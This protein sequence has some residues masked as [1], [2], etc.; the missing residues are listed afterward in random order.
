M[1]SL[2]NTGHAT[3]IWGKDMTYFN[4]VIDLIK[5]SSWKIENNKQLYIK[6]I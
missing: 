5:Q 4:Q 2:D 3:F 6:T 1:I